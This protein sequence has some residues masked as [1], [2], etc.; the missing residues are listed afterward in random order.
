MVAGEPDLLTSAMSTLGPE[1]SL[2]SVLDLPADSSISQ[3]KKNMTGRA[4]GDQILTKKK[5]AG[6]GA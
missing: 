2:P 1:E 6:E 5:M 4:T 3:N